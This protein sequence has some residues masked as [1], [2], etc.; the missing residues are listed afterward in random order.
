[1]LPPVPEVIFVDELVLLSADD[2][3]QPSPPLA[4]DIEIE[5]RIGFTVD[6]AIHDELVQ[7]RIGPP[8]HRLKH[9]M[10]LVQRDVGG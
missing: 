8:H 7:V 1:M 6:L 9:P 2:L 5:R 3:V 4:L 10:Q